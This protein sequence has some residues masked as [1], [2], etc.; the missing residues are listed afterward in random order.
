MIE[1]ILK[2]LRTMSIT[3]IFGILFDDVHCLICNRMFT[4]PFFLGFWR[5]E[6]L[7]V[8]TDMICPASRESDPGCKLKLEIK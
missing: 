4:P 1:V 5:I 6:M 7:S 8:L 3:E 2:I